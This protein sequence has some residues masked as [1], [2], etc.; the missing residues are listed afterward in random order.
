[1]T[2]GYLV[3]LGAHPERLISPRVEALFVRHRLVEVHRSTRLMATASADLDVRRSPTGHGLLLGTVFDTQMRPAPQRME[4]DAPDD[5]ATALTE[6]YWGSYLALVDAGNRTE[7]YRDPSGALPC[8]MASIGEGVILTSLPHLLVEGGLVRGSIDWSVLSHSLLDR[9]SR[10]ARTAIEQISEL[11]PGFLLAVDARAT[12]TSRIWD[13]WAKATPCPQSDPS[14]ALE[15]VLSATLGAWGSLIRRPLIEVSGGLDSSIVAAGLVRTSA[16][17]SLISFAAADGD[18]DERLYAEAL[19]AHLDL[20]LTIVTPRIEEV[21]LTRSLSEELPRPNARAFTQ[22]AD[23]LSLAH[24]MTIGADAFVSGGGGDDLFCYLRSILPALDRWQVEG[25]VPAARTALDVANMN[26]ST[27]WDAL[28]RLGR[29]RLRGAG[30]SIPKLDTRFLSPALIATQRGSEGCRLSKE[31]SGLA[32][33]D[34]HVRGVTSIHNHLEGHRRSQFVPILSP[35]LS[36]PIVET[37]LAIP[38]W[39]WCAQGRNRAVAR[40]AF[41]GWLPQLIIERRSKGSFDAFCAL[42][43]HANRRVVREL[44]LGGTLA[45]QGLLDCPMIEAALAHPSPPAA[46]VSRILSL[47]DAESWAMAW[48]G[49]QRG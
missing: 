29:R 26:H 9:S 37:C 20:P 18:P 41:A 10:D 32:G 6:R 4:F 42:L 8:Y 7:A 48:H 12:V 44:L 39:H 3:I 5:W 27:W 21:D 45:G 40:D 14:D 1:M 2:A 49:H 33:K 23:T 24:G 34:H 36:Q 19:A 30:S 46:T 31:S 38:T 15:R 17:A 11:A 16:D 13:P 25:M 43:L 28:A 35:L 47:I 22:A